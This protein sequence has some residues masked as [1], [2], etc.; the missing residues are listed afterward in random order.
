MFAAI[1]TAAKFIGAPSAAADG[2][3]ITARLLEQFYTTFA[4]L[5]PL[6]YIVITGNKLIAAQVEKGSLAFVLS[7]PLRREQV[8][9]TQAAYLVGSVTAMFA[10]IALIGTVMLAAMGLEVGIGV[11][12]LMNLGIVCFHFTIGGISFAASCIFN[13][14]GKS[15]LVGAGIPVLFFVFNSLA[16]LSPLSAVMGYF[17]YLT[18]NSLYSFPDITSI[19]PNLL[20]QFPLLLVIGAACYAIGI[21]RFKK[22]D[23]PL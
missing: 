16:G 2:G 1:L 5:L 6:I 11:F 13:S 12:L 23:L 3:G 9:L 19:S 4:I 21:L 18:I 22:K 17:K 15:L 10:A 7:R 20:W 8:A 14:S